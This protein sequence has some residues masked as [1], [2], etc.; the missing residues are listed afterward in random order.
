MTVSLK[1]FGLPGDHLG[2]LLLLL[3]PEV[4]LRQEVLDDAVEAGGARGGGQG[5]GRGRRGGRGSPQR[6]PGEGGLE[7]LRHRGDVEDL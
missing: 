7:M 4:V 6:L 5:R 3:Q 2:P 1:L